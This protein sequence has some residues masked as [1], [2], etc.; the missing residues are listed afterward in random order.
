VLLAVPILSQLPPEFVPATS[1]LGGLFLLYLAL[2][3][4]L[5][6]R[7]AVVP[8]GEVGSTAR[9]GLLTG[10]L[11]RLLGPH[12]YLFWL[13]V[14]G[15]TLLRAGQVGWLALAAFLVGYYVTIVGSNVGL[16]VVVHRSIGLLSDRMYRGLLLATSL[17]LAA[18][19]LVLIGRGVSSAQAGRVD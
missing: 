11:A 2:T 4:G 13:F 9:G 12:P 10:V 8:R 1:L 5:S 19:A 18:Y 14:G 7:R 6:S 15:P 3:T 16:A 17:I